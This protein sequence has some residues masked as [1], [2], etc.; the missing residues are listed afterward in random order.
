MQSS[1]VQ[2]ISNSIGVPLT[3]ASVEYGNWIKYHPLTTVSDSTKTKRVKWMWWMWTAPT[4]LCQSR[5][6]GLSSFQHVRPTCVFVRRPSH[7]EFTTWS[8]TNF[9]LLS[10]FQTLAEDIFIWADYA[11]SA[12][13]TILNCLMGYIGVL[14]NSNSNIKPSA[15]KRKAR[16]FWNFTAHVWQE[17]TI[18]SSSV[19]GWNL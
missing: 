7:L 18:T 2:L 6:S 11:F 17:G 10:Y 3:H 14:S 15:F 16:A 4:P 1:P 19:T 9:S 5:T 12:L 8:A 13:E